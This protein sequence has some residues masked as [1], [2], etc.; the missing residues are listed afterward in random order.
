[1]LLLQCFGWLG[2]TSHQ[3][4]KVIWRLSRFIGGGR[5]QMHAFRA[6]FQAW[7]ETWLKSK[8]MGDSNPQRWGATDS[9]S[10]SLTTRSLTPPLILI[11]V[12][13]M[14]EIPVLQHLFFNIVPDLKYWY[15]KYNTL[16]IQISI[17]NHYV[18]YTA[19]SGTAV[20][21]MRAHILLI[22]VFN[23]VIYSVS[24]VFPSSHLRNET[25]H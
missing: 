11:K 19:W 24:I 8:S 3:Y 18:N 12:A 23:T 25:T 2:V 21:A 22:F 10:T 7:T 9:K 6:L 16:K 4:W 15:W 14:G 5:P 13:F 17:R 1:M 20:Y